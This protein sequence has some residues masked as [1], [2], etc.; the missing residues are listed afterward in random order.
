[1]VVTRSMTR[2]EV[3]K[4]IRRVLSTPGISTVIASKCDTMDQGILSLF[5]L[6]NDKRMRHELQTYVDVMSLCKE[7]EHHEQW[8]V[9]KKCIIVGKIRRH[10]DGIECT[11]GRIYKA[12]R[13]IKMFKYICKC[14]HDILLLGKTFA[15]S[16]DERIE[17][18]IQEGIDHPKIH[19]L[20][21]HMNHFR[22]ELSEMITWGKSY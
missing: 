8:M 21:S 11:Q 22:N 6:F 15:R 7:E 20:I 12:R 5:M 18:L 4:N 1:M 9:N 2:L 14:G 3:G 19:F 13:V 17:Y 16:L 10:L